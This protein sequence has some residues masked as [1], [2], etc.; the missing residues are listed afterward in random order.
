MIHEIVS[1]FFRERRLDDGTTL[2]DF[3]GL[4]QDQEEEANVVERRKKVA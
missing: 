2:R 1:F 4:P 3:G